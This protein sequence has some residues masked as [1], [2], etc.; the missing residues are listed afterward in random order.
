MPSRPYRICPNCKGRINTARCPDCEKKRQP[1]RDTKTEAERKFYGSARWK[2]IRARQRQKQPLCETCLAKGIVRAMKVA[3]HKVPIRRGGDPEDPDNIQ[4][5]CDECH[6]QK[7]QE[8]AMQERER[9][10]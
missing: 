2:R 1:Q 7:R 3:D 6:N 10:A 4:S 8:E 5:Q 9:V